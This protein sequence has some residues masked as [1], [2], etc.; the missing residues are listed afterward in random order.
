M[1][2]AVPVSS[3]RTTEHFPLAR[4]SRPAA[5]VAYRPLAVGVRA[6]TAAVSPPHAVLSR[7]PSTVDR[8]P[9][10]LPDAW[11]WQPLMTVA[12]GALMVSWF[13]PTMPALPEWPWQ[14]RVLV[15]PDDELAQPVGD[16]GRPHAVAVLRV[17]PLHKQRPVGLPGEHAEDLLQLGEVEAGERVLDPV[18][19]PV[20]QAEVD[21]EDVDDGDEVVQRRGQGD[22]RGLHRGQPGLQVTVSIAAF[23]VAGSAPR[24]S[25]ST[26]RAARSAQRSSRESPSK[27]RRHGRRRRC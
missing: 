11:W 15:V 9:P 8:K 2:E 20:E 7:P 13:P 14:A 1:P 16:V 24:V 3:P 4:F 26:V 5:T 18:H 25:I 12:E 23:R 27:G 10:E 22:E 21:G 17:R 6:P 19:P